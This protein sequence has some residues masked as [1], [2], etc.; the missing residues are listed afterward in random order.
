MAWNLDV[1]KAAFADR[2]LTLYLGAGVSVPS[3]LPNW[4]R[5]VLMMYLASLA[6]GAEQDNPLRDWRVFPNYLEAIAQWLLRES[7]DPAEITAQKILAKV[8]PERFI[9]LLKETLYGTLDNGG[10]APNGTLDGV[11]RLCNDTGAGVRAVVTYNYDDLLEQRV[12]RSQPVWKPASAPEAGKLPVYHVHGYLP[13]DRGSAASEGSTYPELVLTEE[14]FHGAASDAYS[15]SNL[16]QLRQL[17][18][19][20]GLMVGM[21]LRD[22]NLRRLLDAMRKL[23]DRCPQYAVLKRELDP[24]EPTAIAEIEK[25]AAEYGADRKLEE[26]SAREIQAIFDRLRSDDQQRTSVVLEGLGVEVLW[27]DDYAEIPR[28]LAAIADG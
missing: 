26:R 21:S 5:L 3:G 1:L 20:V 6:E 17:G 19:N 23:Q 16:V 2:E 11:G 24:L 4:D 10:E 15:W 22:R 18:S 7:V 25:L 13:P 12:E 9:P 8:G 27:V 14:Q 28:V